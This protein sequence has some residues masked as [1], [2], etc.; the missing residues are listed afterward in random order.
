MIIHQRVCKNRGL[1][2]KVF[3]NQ[4]VGELTLPLQPY[5]GVLIHT[6]YCGLWHVFIGS[7]LH[8][9]FLRQVTGWSCS[10]SESRL[11]K[12][13][14]LKTTPM[15]VVGTGKHTVD[16]SERM[17]SWLKQINAAQDTIFLSLPQPQMTL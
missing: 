7:A 9:T 2:R 14:D 6:L 17:S 1:E 16:D 5:H 12:E 3:G 13:K 15:P 10:R 8:R 11:C 4:E